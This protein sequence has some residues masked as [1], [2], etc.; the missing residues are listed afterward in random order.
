MVAAAAW[1]VQVYDA[2]AGQQWRVVGSTTQQG[3]TSQQ[4]PQHNSQPCS[5]GSAEPC[6]AGTLVV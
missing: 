5:D 3:S 6:K 1:T 4:G 2:A